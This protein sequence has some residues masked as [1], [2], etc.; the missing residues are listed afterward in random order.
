MNIDTY[1][2]LH[3]QSLDYLR[4]ATEGPETAH[5]EKNRVHMA[6]LIG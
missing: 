3:L 1:F 4:I 5:A 6:S 2:I